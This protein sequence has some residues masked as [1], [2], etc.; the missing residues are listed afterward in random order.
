[1]NSTNSSQR[2]DP[3]A[4]SLGLFSIGLGL[5]EIFAHREVARLIGVKNRPG[6]FIALGIREILSGVGILAQKRPAG[7]LW[8]RVAG[9]VMDLSLLGVAFTESSSDKPRVEG[10]AAAVAGVM[11]ADVVAA[12]QHSRAS[13]PLRVEKVITIDRAPEELYE[14]WRRFDN[15]PRFMRNL[16]AVRVIDGRRSHWVAR[17][18][19][20][21]SIHWDAEIV[22]ERPGE[23]ISWRALPGGDISTSGSVR[24]ERAPGGRGTFVRVQMQYDPP[25]GF[26][27]ASIAK[28]L[29]DDPDTL[30]QRDLY[31][32]KQVMETGQ[33]ST[34]EGQPA[35]RASSTSPMYD[36]DNVRS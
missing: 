29:G 6:V 23:F 26:F 34:T 4:A 20:R 31:R 11:L 1:M 16:D 22:D 30:V 12:V 24:F 14:F 5:A 7:W 27:G 9:D 35:G 10:A 3:F 17:G 19:G 8:S 15:L 21:S 18:P 13:G 33:V 25:G 36:T 32:F 28:L 2:R